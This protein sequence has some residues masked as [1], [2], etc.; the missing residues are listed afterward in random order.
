LENWKVV[1]REVIF[2]RGNLSLML[3][4]A[5][6]VNWMVNFLAK[7]R[8]RNASLKVENTIFGVLHFLQHMYFF[9]LFRFQVMPGAPWPLPPTCCAP[10]HLCRPFPPVTAPSL[11]PAL[12]SYEEAPWWTEVSPPR[13]MPRNW[14]TQFS[15]CQYEV[16]ARN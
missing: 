12:S 14:W 13:F 8:L 16:G 6:K 4:V 15:S 11:H 9:Y 2:Y 7:S 3:Y 1:L 5:S 10:N